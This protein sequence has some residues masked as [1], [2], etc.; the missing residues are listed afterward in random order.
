MFVIII[1][2]QNKAYRRKKKENRKHFSEG[3]EEK[4]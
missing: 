1:S 3:I 4:Y 2:Q